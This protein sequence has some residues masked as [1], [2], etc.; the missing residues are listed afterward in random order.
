MPR[1]GSRS[2]GQRRDGMQTVV[3][4][5]TAAKMPLR[6][7]RPAQARGWACLSMQTSRIAVDKGRWCRSE[8]LVVT[9]S[10]C[11]ALWL[12]NIVAARTA[13]R[14]GHAA[15]VSLHA[16][17]I[18]SPTARDKASAMGPKKV[19]MQARPAGRTPTPVTAAGNSL[20]L[21]TG[22]PAG[23]LLVEL[24]GSR[25]IM[26]TVASA[27]VLCLTGCSGGSSTPAA[28]VSPSASPSLSRARAR[29]PARPQRGC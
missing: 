22:R 23:C 15:V 11:R 2:G 17:S 1:T 18:R 14:N 5:S 10:R 28:L 7:L 27:V 24:A 26:I 25:R 4:N 12:L 19:V 9:W 8:T 21:R 29:P 16:V 6:C 20:I 3:N 13:V